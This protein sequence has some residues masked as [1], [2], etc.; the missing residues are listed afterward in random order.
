MENEKKILVQKRGPKTHYHQTT[1]STWA[2]AAYTLPYRCFMET[3]LRGRLYQASEAHHRTIF[4]GGVDGERRGKYFKNPGLTRWMKF[5]LHSMDFQI[6]FNNKWGP[7]PI[8]KINK[9]PCGDFFFF[10]PNLPRIFWGMS[11]DR[12]RKKP[13]SI[14][15]KKNLKWLMDGLNSEYLSKQATSKQNG[16]YEF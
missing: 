5:R 16:T 4:F 12:K 3:W 2:R 7:K 8:S 15:K 1:G 10:K 11:F 6:S 14:L 13:A 9:L